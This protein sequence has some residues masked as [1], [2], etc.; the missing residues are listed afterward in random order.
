[1]VPPPFDA[2][3]PHVTCARWSPAVAATVCGAPGIVRG[4][5][6]GDGADAE[7]V[8]FAF[9]A[10]TVNVYAV[11]LVSPCT[12]AGN[13][14]P[15]VAL[16]PVGT[17]GTVAGV[18]ALDAEDGTLL[19]AAFVATTVNVYDVPLVRPVTSVERTPAPT[20]TGVPL[21]LGVTV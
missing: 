16:T 4:V 19:P 17:P 2:G 20:V 9:V 8:P 13:L 18:T 12:L 3:A 1:M 7:P 5:T 14:A 10:G 15:S 6:D 21:G 11:P